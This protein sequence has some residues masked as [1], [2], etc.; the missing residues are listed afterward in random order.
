MK[1]RKTAGNAFL[2][3]HDA[4]GGKESFD[5]CCFC[6]VSVIGLSANNRHQIVYPNLNSAMRPVPRDDSLPVVEPPENGLAF[7]E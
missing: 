4:A 3:S 6:C 1:K 5:D 7:L 2:F